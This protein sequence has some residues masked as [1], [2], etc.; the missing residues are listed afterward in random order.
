MATDGIASSTSGI[1]I[2][3][4]DSC[5]WMSW[6]SNRGS[7]SEDQEDEPEHV[8]RG[9]EG[10]YQPDDGQYLPDRNQIRDPGP[11]EDLV[12]RPEPGEGNHAGVGE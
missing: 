11:D 12:L 5:G 9:E 10:R 4:G 6:G 2:D 1:A 7:P 3:G 8:E